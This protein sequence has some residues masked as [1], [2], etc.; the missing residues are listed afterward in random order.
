MIHDFLAHFGGEHDK[1]DKDMS[2]IFCMI[3]FM[4]LW[5]HKI[6]ITRVTW[7]HIAINSY[8][9]VDVFYGHENFNEANTSSNY[10]F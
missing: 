4:I 10:V 5:K 6:F 2:K 8:K 1:Y 7:D 3:F 9:V